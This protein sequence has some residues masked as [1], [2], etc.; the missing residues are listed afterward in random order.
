MTQRS[1][2]VSIYGNMVSMSQ[3]SHLTFRVTPALRE[4]LSRAVSSEPSFNVS[5]IARVALERAVDRALAKGKGVERV[6]PK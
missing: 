4:R 6:R 1:G 3:A 5:R 2:A